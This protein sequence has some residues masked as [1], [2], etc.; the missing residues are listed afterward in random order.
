MRFAEMPGCWC[1]F[2]ARRAS[3]DQ[4][5][6]AAR[7]AAS[8]R[9][10]AA[11]AQPQTC[12]T[13]VPVRA[14]SGLGS[15]YA[16]PFSG[17]ATRRTC[18]RLNS[19]QTAA[20]RPIPGDDSPSNALLEKVILPSAKCRV[21]GGLFHAPTTAERLKRVPEAAKSQADG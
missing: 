13:V 6:H 5:N 3:L 4:H 17:G 7:R 11:R 9:A 8:R 15:V 19:G 1:V 10:D 14:R 20:A 18:S 16:C 21:M 12:E 2:G